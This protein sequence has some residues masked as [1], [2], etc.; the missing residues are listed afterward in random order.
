MATSIHRP[1]RLLVGL[2]LACAAW[3]GDG[4]CL[5]EP[6]TTIVGRVRAVDGG[7]ISAQPNAWV[8]VVAV[9]A[10]GHIV[11]RQATDD[12]F[13]LTVPSDHDYVL[14]ISSDDG[15]FGVLVWGERE[16]PEF[17]ARG[18]PIDLGCVGLNRDTSRAFALRELDLRPPR[19][20]ARGA[21]EAVLVTDE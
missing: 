14:M 15:V 9:D 11:A 13:R 7:T 20:A 2:L 19:Q 3:T 6:E 10:E 12:A 4:E 1:G 16:R 21:S 8:T 17:A 5:G 18:G